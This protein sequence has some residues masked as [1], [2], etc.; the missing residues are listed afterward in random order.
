ME[1]L[2]ER[3]RQGKGEKLQ[4]VEKKMRQTGRG[5]KTT[6]LKET[7]RGERARVDI[8]TAWTIVERKAQGKRQ[9]LGPS[10]RKGARLSVLLGEAAVCKVRSRC[11]AHW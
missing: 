6:W 1:K 8:L 7:K 5:I 2:P 3:K 10:S 4:N 11:G 9:L